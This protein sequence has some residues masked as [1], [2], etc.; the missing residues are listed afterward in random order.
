MLVTYYIML[1]Y[2][3]NDTESFYCVMCKS[4]Y[5]ISKKARHERSKKHK[6]FDLL[7]KSNVNKMDHDDVEVTKQQKDIICRI[8][9]LAKNLL[10]GNNFKSIENEETKQ[11]VHCIFIKKN[12][13]ECIRTLK[14]K[15][16]NVE[17]WNEKISK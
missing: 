15:Y 12:H 11:F 10:E 4:Y 8:I 6:Y 13:A 2:N 17:I 9:T 7:S 1:K 14:L 5:T 3:S 16:N